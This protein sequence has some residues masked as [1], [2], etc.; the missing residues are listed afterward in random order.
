LPIFFGLVAGSAVGG[1]MYQV[2][3]RDQARPAL[4]WGVAAAVGF[5][6]IGGLLVMNRRMAHR[7]P[8][9]DVISK[10]S[11]RVLASRAAPVAALVLVP[12]VVLAG[13]SVGVV[14]PPAGAGPPVA[15]DGSV[16]GALQSA[17][18][19]PI[20]GTTDEGASTSQVVT[21]PAGARNV[22]FTLR[23]T[24]E[25]SSSPAGPL[26]LPVQP[27]AN[28]PDTFALHVAL[29]NGSML[30]DENA[31]PQGGEGSVVLSLPAELGAG[32]YNVTVELTNAGDAQVAPGVAAPG[33]NDAS[34]AWT[35]DVAYRTPV[36]AP[37][38]P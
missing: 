7:A 26:P 36:A 25:P 23:W 4:Y 21:L 1:V 22:T 30:M 37:T 19:A 18:L 24:D 2:F 38:P 17:S 27:A 6:C 20:N 12:L 28:Q 35:L 9:G 15:L 13:M 11:E 5:A 8:A 14:Q 10:R 33:G 32:S 3:V 34:N 16:P 31:N 29:P